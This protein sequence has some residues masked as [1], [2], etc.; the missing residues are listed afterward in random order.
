MTAELRELTEVPCKTCPHRREPHIP[1]PSCTSDNT[2]RRQ[3]RWLNQ[4]RNRLEE[5][6]TEEDEIAAKAQPFA[7]EPWYY[8]WCHLKSLRESNTKN[9]ESIRVY[10]LADRNQLKKIGDRVVPVDCEDHPTRRRQI[11]VEDG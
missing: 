10:I 4:W 11:E 2:N 5:R 7:R 9:D 3:L 1:E 8:P 6:E